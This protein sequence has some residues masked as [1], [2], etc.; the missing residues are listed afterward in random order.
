MSRGKPDY[1][2]DCRSFDSGH[3]FFASSAGASAEHRSI[4]DIP[5][6]I[7]VRAP[8]NRAL[9]V[10]KDGCSHADLSRPQDHERQVRQF[11]ALTRRRKGDRVAGVLPR[12]PE[13]LAIMIGTWKAGG[14]YVPIFSGFGRDAIAFR[15]GHAAPRSFAPTINIV[16]VFRSCLK[17]E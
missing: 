11:V 17:S 9:L 4:L 6:S 1:H 12:I 14:V 10:R 15:I 13:T 5:S 8:I 7:A 3:R 16:A 2:D